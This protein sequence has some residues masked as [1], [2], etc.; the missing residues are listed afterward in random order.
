M[1]GAILVTLQIANAES[2]H[3][4]GTL[5]ASSDGLAALHRDG[6]ITLSSNG[7]LWITDNAGDANIEVQGRGYIHE[8]ASG[9]ARYLGFEGTANITDNDV[10]VALSGAEIE[11]KAV[12][13]SRFFLRGIGEYKVRSQTG[14]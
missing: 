10:T 6:E 7:V 1:V 2:G 5:T 13:S 4:T 12:R 11:L 14:D 8:F 3:K 9:L